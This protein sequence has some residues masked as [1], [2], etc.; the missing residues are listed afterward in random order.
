MNFM[1]SVLPA[2]LS[3]LRAAANNNDDNNNSSSSR[4]SNNNNNS[5]GLDRALRG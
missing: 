3:P 2:P 4:S 5:V 1:L